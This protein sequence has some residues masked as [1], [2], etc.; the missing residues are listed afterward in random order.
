MATR[1]GAHAQRLSAVRALRTVKARREQQRFLFEGVTMLGEAVAAGFP[2][3]ELYVTH[4]AYDSTPLIRE[5]EAGGTPVFLVGDA[6]LARV[7]DV[8]TPSGIVAVA[9]ARMSQADAL[10]RTGKRALILAD[11]NDPTN[12]GALLRSADAFDCDSVLFGALGIGPY[13]PK[14][15]RGSMGAIFRL[16]MGVINPQ[17]AAV[18]SRAAGVRMLGLA[19]GGT[20]IAAEHWEPPYALI[21]GNERHG[22]GPWEAACTGMLAIPIATRAESL[23]AAVAGSIALYEARRS[24]SCQESV[25]GQKSQDYRGQKSHGILSQRQ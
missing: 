19:T 17:D 9:E 8:T 22:L 2:I 23:S 16:A 3:A 18:A 25:L 7:S 11:L 1:L 5:V 10:L 15:V 14:V 12:A 20:P 6:A 13:H 24:E 21:V 4:D